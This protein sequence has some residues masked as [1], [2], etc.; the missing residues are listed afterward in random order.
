M[1]L[2]QSS[3]WGQ[4]WPGNILLASSPN[5]I[6]SGDIIY[7]WDTVLVSW[8]VWENSLNTYD[9]IYFNKSY[10][11]GQEWDTLYWL[12]RNDHESWNPALAISGNRF[13]SIWHDLR[14][15][16]DTTYG[17]YFSHWPYQDTT[18]ID[19]EEAQRPSE[20]ALSAYP[21]PFNSSTLISITGEG[22]SIIKIYDIE[23]RLVRTLTCNN[24]ESSIIWNAKDE[25]GNAISSGIYFANSFTESNRKQGQL[26]LLYIK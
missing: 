3:D 16:P 8:E 4:T 10:N 9:K 12:D 7:N 20:I 11:L 6:V 23:G 26:K 13:F 25:K 1:N 24:N 14:G 21:N 19:N 17:L 22:I 5:G 15:Y 18:G 2:S